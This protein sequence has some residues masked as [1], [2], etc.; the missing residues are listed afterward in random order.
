[1]SVN[2]GK[3][4]EAGHLQVNQLHVNNSLL[5]RGS[6]LLL[7]HETHDHTIGTNH[8]IVYFKYAMELE[9]T[10]FVATSGSDKVQIHFSKNHHF[11]NSD[12]GLELD[13]VLISFA[14]GENLRGHQAEDFQGN[15]DVDFHAD[16]SFEITMSINSTSTGQIAAPGKCNILIY[17]YLDLAGPGSTW[18]V[19]YGSA[20]GALHT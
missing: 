17:K 5:I 20:P 15:F 7:P 13:N 2:I 19:T 8:S 1:M 10:H 16:K 11:T 3:F 6:E 14:D 12:T 9:I 4:C 18:A